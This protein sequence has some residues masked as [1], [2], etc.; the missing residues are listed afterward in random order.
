[1][2]LV[3]SLS[4]IDDRTPFV[5]TKASLL[6][7]LTNSGFSVP[8]GFVITSRAYRKFLQSNNLETRILDIYKEINFEDKSSIKS[9]SEKI[10]TMIREAKIP[11]DVIEQIRSGYASFANTHGVEGRA[12]ELI[13]AGR[14]Q[15]SVTIRPSPDSKNTFA[16]LFSSSNDIKGEEK[17]LK[18]IKK[19]WES[20]HYEEA[21]L[22]RKVSNLNHDMDMAVIIQENIEPEYAGT[23]VVQKDRV[24]IE[25]NFGPA[26]LILEGS[27]TPDMFIVNDSFIGERRISNKQFV[28]VKDEVNGGYRKVTQGE[29]ATKPSLDDVEVNKIANL[30]RKVKDTLNYPQI[31]EWCVSR[32]KFKILQTRPHTKSV[33]YNKAEAGTLQGLSVSNGYTSGKVEMVD[34]YV[35]SS[36]DASIGVIGNPIPYASIMYDGLISD[37][38]SYS[39]HAAVICRELGKPAIFGTGDATKTL[40][41]SQKVTIDGFEGSVYLQDGEEEDFFEEVVHTEAEAKKASWIDT[42]AHA[43]SAESTLDGSDLVFVDIKRVAQLLLGEDRQGNEDHDAVINLI[44][45]LKNSCDMKNIPLHL[46]WDERPNEDTVEK[47]KSISSVMIFKD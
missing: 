31:V 34:S 38:G 46:I 9:N 18:S 44:K 28:M 24:I 1:M 5:G 20:L 30:A 36:S 41:S 32:G 4:E 42:P 45:S 8:K 12:L 10:V 7:V 15:P 35:N 40:H 13:K 26:E 11:Q 27:I 17:L 39:C 33:E 43:L 25:S 3:V 2:S 47:Y 14:D 16:G 23:A 21:I 37:Y 29:K 19:V 22:Y 6:G